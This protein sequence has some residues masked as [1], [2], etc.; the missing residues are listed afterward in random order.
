MTAGQC[1]RYLVLAEHT[2]QCAA[3]LSAAG[4]DKAASRAQGEH[5]LQ[6]AHA[7]PAATCPLLYRIVQKKMRFSV[8]LLNRYKP[9]CA[10][11][12][13]HYLSLALDCFG[14]SFTSSFG[15]PAHSS[16]LLFTLTT[17]RTKSPV[18]VK[19]SVKKLYTTCSG[20]TSRLTPSVRCPLRDW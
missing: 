8:S 2:A 14:V 5:G 15:G 10:P 4:P 6:A 18:A 19:S 20:P 12:F 16:S 3:L 11:Y 9:Q 17:I 13:P 1:C 7:P